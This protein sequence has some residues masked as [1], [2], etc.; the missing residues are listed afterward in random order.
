MLTPPKPLDE[1]NEIWCVSYSHEWGV[2]RQLF[3]APPPGALGRGQKV[4]YH[5]ISIT[6][7]ILKFF[8]PNFVYVLTNEDTKRFRRDFTS[9]TWVLPQGSDFGALGVPR[10]SFFS[11]HDHVAYQIDGDASRTE[12]K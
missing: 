1:F 10:R 4:K 12:C 3:L 7:S 11:K 2:Q 9:V 6:K 8:I 5:I